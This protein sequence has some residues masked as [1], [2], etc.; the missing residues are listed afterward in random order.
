[1]TITKL[2]Y[3]VLSLYL[4]ERRGV[5]GNTSM[6]LREFPRAQPEGTPET[7]CWYFLYSPLESRY[8]HY[9]IYKSDEALAI[10]IAIAMY[11]AIAI[12][13]PRGRKET[14]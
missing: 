2:C 10:S 3:T 13:K 12:S 6:R 8:R 4:D 9:P 14:D 1:M 11:R 7:E 5:Q